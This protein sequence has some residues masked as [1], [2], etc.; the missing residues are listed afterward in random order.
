MKI[1]FVLLD[2]IKISVDSV[3]FSLYS[4]FGGHGNATGAAENM[5]MPFFNHAQLLSPVGPSYEVPPE[6]L[7]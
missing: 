6:Y 2:I 1:K 5:N 7:I 4:D 3:F